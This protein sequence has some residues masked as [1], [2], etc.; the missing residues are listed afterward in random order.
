MLTDIF[1]IGLCSE[2]FQFSGP[3]ERPVLKLSTGGEH[4]GLKHNYL[5]L[6]KNVTRPITFALI[7]YEIHIY[8][9]LSYLG[10]TATKS[11]SLKSLYWID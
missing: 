3:H 6:D 8:K 1:V 11:A 5:W 7:K 9:S 10:I 4:D 2:S